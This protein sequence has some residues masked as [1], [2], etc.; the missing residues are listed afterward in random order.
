EA[1]DA[2]E[3]EGE[4]DEV[5][6]ALEAKGLATRSPDPSDRR[7][8]LV[9]LTDQGRELSEEVRRARGAEAERLFERLTADDRAELARLLEKLQAP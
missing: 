1:G 4:V 5:E 9:T 6:E 7:A 2:V 3:E 8:T